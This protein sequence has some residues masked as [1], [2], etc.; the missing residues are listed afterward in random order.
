[1]T[2]TIQEQREELQQIIWD[3]AKD[4]TGCRPRWIDFDNSTIEELEATLALYSKMAAEQAE[5][6]AE[7]DAEAVRDYENAIEQSI[8]LGAGDRETAVRWLIDA[9][10][11]A[12]GYVDVDHIMWSMGL[13]GFTP[14]VQY[15]KAELEAAA[16]QAQEA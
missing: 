5:L 7:M 12:D 8:E 11:T 6:E 9:N 4:A 3:V 15:I 13:P 2:N 1:M 14:E 16:Q 10:T